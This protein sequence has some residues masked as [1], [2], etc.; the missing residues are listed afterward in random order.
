MFFWKAFKKCTT[1]GHE[2]KKR[3][4]FVDDDGLTLIG[5]EAN[6]N[7]LGLGLFLFDHTC[8]TTL[9]L[10]VDRFRDLY[11][12]EVFK[13]RKTGTEECPGH[14]MHK[15]KLDP[16]PAKCECGWVRQLIQI[17]ARQ[18]GKENKPK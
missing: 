7:A 6:F 3:K 18:G 2:W 15:S 11:K 5:Y 16:C 12:G 9:A 17:L 10:P 13:E 4:D 8:G 14:C 1:C